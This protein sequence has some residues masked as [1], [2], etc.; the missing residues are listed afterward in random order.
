MTVRYK[1]CL[2]AVKLFEYHDIEL[3]RAEL[4]SLSIFGNIASLT[5]GPQL[6]SVSANNQNHFKMVLIT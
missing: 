6:Q 4:L 5:Y 2:F 1:I 3:D